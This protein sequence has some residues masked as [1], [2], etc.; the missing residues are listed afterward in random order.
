MV[1][2]VVWDLADP[3]LTLQWKVG[4]STPLCAIAP[5]R[6]PFCLGLGA[7]SRWGLPLFGRRNSWWIVWDPFGGEKG[8]EGSVTENEVATVV[9]DAAYKIHTMLGPGLLESVYERVFVYELSRRGLRVQRQ[10]SIP[11]VYEGLVVED[12]FRADLVVEG[13][14]IVEIKSTETTPPVYKK[15]LLTYLRLSG[16]KLGMLVN[17]GTELV[18]QGISRVANGVLP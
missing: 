5:P 13:I 6:A 7:C 9:V 17:F 12:A 10:V 11:I 18:K 2:S 8:L 4:P 14:V 16:L 3:P 15:Q 1:G